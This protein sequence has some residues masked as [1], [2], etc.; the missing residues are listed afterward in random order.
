MTSMDDQCMP[1]D[2]SDLFSFRE[3]DF[4]HLDNECI[5]NRKSFRTSCEQKCHNHKRLYPSQLA[6]GH[7]AGNEEEL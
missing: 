6:G 1:G 3:S 2:R 5:Q 7:D 4:L